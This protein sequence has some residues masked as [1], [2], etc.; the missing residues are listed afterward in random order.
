MNQQLIIVLL[1]AT[2]LGLLIALSVIAASSRRLR[3][4][5]GGLIELAGRLAEGAGPSNHVLPLA[6]PAARRLEESMT[7][8]AVRLRQ[9]LTQVTVVEPDVPAEVAA[10]FRELSDADPEILRLVA[11]EGLTADELA[12]VFDCSANAAR[13]RLHRARSRFTEALHSPSFTS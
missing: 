8:L 10:A 13:I 7:A 2:A 9:E 6:D 3:R 12:L 11:W 1:G 4:E 5:I